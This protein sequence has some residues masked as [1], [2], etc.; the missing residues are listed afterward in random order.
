MI[1]IGLKALLNPLVDGRV[2]PDVAPED[3]QYPLIT[4]QQVGGMSI[5][6]LEKEMPSH[7]DARI[8]IN[9]WSQGRIE[10]STIA[11]QIE[12][13]ICESDFIASPLGAAIAL[14]EDAVKLY[15]TRQDFRIHYP[16]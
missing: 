10:A 5:W 4:Y 3:P 2:F 14:Y 9:V 1:E 15:G 7:L 6:Y 11:L 16:N 12:R 8:Q 13:A